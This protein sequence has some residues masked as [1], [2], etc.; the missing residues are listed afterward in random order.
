MRLVEKL[1][2]FERQLVFLNWGTTAEYGKIL[3]V[4]DDFV[5]FEVFSPDSMEYTEKVLINSQLI[6]EVIVFSTDI[7]RLAM[8]YA[9]NLPFGN[10]DK[11]DSN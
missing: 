4:G 5:E 9:S 1:K 2:Q 3:Y 11:T 8:E 6:L 7:S 10:S